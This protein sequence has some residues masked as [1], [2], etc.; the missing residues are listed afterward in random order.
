MD[1]RDVSPPQPVV[2][3]FWCYAQDDRGIRV[4]LEKYLSGLRHR[5]HILSQE[6]QEIPP[7]SD[8]EKT[9]KNY[10]DSSDL[11]ILLVSADFLASCLYGGQ[12]M[13]QILKRG[14]HE[15]LTIISVL[16]KEIVDQEPSLARYQTLPRNGR[17]LTRSMHRSQT[18][19]EIAKEI[20]EIVHRL[21]SHKYKHFGDN[22]RNQGKYKH[23]LDAYE[24]GVHFAPKDDLRH[25]ATL[26]KDIGEMLLRL[27]EF[28]KALEA[29]EE[30][31]K[32]QP[33]FGAAYQMKGDVLKAYAPHAQKRLLQQAQEAHQTAID[34][35][36]QKREGRGGHQ[37]GS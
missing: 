31:I 1:D 29:C 9:L 2:Q 25:R 12:A 4:N 22:W 33:N 36:R 32:L 30:A 10:I 24:E 11:V 17:P 19:A 3:I 35:K 16:V 21:L 26:H 5:G 8:R 13:S 20:C 6:E 18:Y 28:E 23:A 14:E 7:G 15:E 27:G 34:I 37:H